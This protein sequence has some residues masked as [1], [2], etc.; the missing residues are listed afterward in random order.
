MIFVDVRREGSSVDVGTLD[1][2]L[3]SFHHAPEAHG[4]RYVVLCYLLIIVL[5][6]LP[7]HPF[8]FFI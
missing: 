4:Y 8:Y 3:S 2:L 1:G 6:L 5:S 7:F